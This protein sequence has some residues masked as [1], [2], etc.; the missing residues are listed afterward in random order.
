MKRS[1][2]FNF[3]S[4]LVTDPV[5]YNLGMQFGLITNICSAN[6]TRDHGWMIIELEGAE[7]D[8]ERGIAWV[9]SKG[10]KVGPADDLVE[11]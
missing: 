9:T 1:V 8:I 11:G 10:V 6:I 5:I 4:E 2:T 7:E 3:P